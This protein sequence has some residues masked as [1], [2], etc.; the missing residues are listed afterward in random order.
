MVELNVSEYRFKVE[1]TAKIDRALGQTRGQ[2]GVLCEPDTSDYRCA[3]PVF[4]VTFNATTDHETVACGQRSA[5]QK[6][7]SNESK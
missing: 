7:Q 1:S 4:R 5:G 6:N 3:K 2:P